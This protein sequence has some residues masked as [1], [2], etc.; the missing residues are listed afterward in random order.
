M[1]RFVAGGTDTL[2]INL[3]IMQCQGN[4][5]MYNFSYGWSEA[6]LGHIWLSGLLL[7][8]ASELYHIWVETDM[9]KSVCY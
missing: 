8:P 7:L 5:F 1:M 2:C 9:L 4:G 6:G 3:C